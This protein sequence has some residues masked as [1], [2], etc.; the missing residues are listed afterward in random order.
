MQRPVAEHQRA[1]QALERSADLSPGADC[2]LC[3]Q[4]LGDAFGRVQ[5]HRAQELEDAGRRSRQAAEQEAREA[6]AAREALVALD[7]VSRTVDEARR[8]RSA[9]EQAQSRRSVVRDRLDAALADALEGEP[10]LPARWQGRR[11]GL[12][13]LTAAM[14]E[15]RASHAAARRARD[16]ASRLQGRLERRPQ[17]EKA[18]QQ[19]RDRAAAAGSVTGSLRAKVKAL[20]YEPAALAAAAARAEEAGRAAEATD[21][22]ARAA[23]M[24][25][26][27]AAARDEAQAQRLAEAQAQHAQ[28]GELES[29]TV[30]LG[31]TAELLNG[32]RNSVVASVGPRLA[33]QAAELFSE[34][35][36]NE[37][38]R[39][40]VDTETYGLKIS[41][42]GLA[43]DLDRFSG[44]E[45]DLANLALRVAI[46][47]HVRFQS[48]GTVGLLVLDEVFGPLDEERKA[49]MLMALERLRGRFRQV[50]VVTHSTD[51][52]DQL[53][54]AVEV[55][56]RPGR[57]ATARVVDP[58]C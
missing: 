27:R 12:G 17:A 38:D 21:A 22:A 10:S 32:F 13:N 44:S 16:E 30:H 53:P 20:G 42:A 9:W 48:G 47:E 6:T 24:E 4:A 29:A 31:R 15:V 40:E 45:V 36:D 23:R 39:L 5:A 14:E 1:L 50:L 18:L 46:S 51:I 34:L 3:G 7:V 26:A 35:T 19:A 28:L 58:F 33:V 25:A 56:K 41:D 52:K 11:P 49:R 43:Y 57:R 54:N 37:Y 55:V 2:P 8:T